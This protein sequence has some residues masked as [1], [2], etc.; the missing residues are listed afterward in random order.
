MYETE[1]DRPASINLV[2]NLRMMPFP[3]CLK[4]DRNAADMHTVYPPTKTTRC[5][6]RT[7]EDLASEF[8]DLIYHQSLF[9]ELV[10][11]LIDDH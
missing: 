3:T 5:L 1:S 11:R 6:L 8:P 4:Q 9:A 2:N 7:I 10:N